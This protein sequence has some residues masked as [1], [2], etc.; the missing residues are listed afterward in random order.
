MRAGW[1]VSLFLHA[2]AL[3]ALSVALRLHS[4]PRDL[5]FAPVVPVEAIISDVTDIAPIASP[6]PA[7]QLDFQPEP[8]GAP[9]ESLPEPLALP[10]RALDPAPQ[11]PPPQK[12]RETRESLD[13]NDLSKLLDRSAKTEGARGPQ[14]APNAQ[15]GEKPR[16]AVGAGSALTAVAEA[17]VRALLKEDMR[18]CWRDNSDAPNPERLLVRVRFRLDPS[19]ALVGPPQ[20]LTAI[21]PGDQEML[22]AGQRALTAVR[23]CA[24]YNDLPADQYRIWDEV[25]IKF[26]GKEGIQ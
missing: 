12:P 25:T 22:V 1:I 5:V 6:A 14:S 18:R 7:E 16:E 2:A 20:L 24:P 21:P 8:E 11:K 15:Q 23:A 19:G 26:G 13:L 10:E 17:K 3:A 9:L 4:P